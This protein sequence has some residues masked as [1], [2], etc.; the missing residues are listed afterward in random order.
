MMKSKIATFLGMFNAEN[1]AIFY[2][3]MT[4]KSRLDLDPNQ[5]SGQISGL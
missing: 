4:I 1:V 2:T 3:A 5:S